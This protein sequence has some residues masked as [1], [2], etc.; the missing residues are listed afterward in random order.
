MRSVIGPLSLYRMALLNSY[1]SL[2][3]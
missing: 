3:K 1:S 2:R